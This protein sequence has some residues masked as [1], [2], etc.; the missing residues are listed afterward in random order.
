MENEHKTTVNLVITRLNM[1]SGKVLLTA[2]A[3]NYHDQLVNGS[4]ALDRASL[5]V[6]EIGE[7]QA[8]VFKYPFRDPIVK[9]ATNRAPFQYYSDVYYYLMGD[10]MW[11]QAADIEYHKLVPTATL[12]NSYDE[13][14]VLSEEEL[15]T[16]WYDR[17]KRV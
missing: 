16:E 4:L 8:S 12:C 2:V 10:P 17:K 9:E 3:N 15:I 5:P 14:L 11:V 13:A 7:Y 1:K 6:F